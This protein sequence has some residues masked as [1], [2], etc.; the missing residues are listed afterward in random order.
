MDARLSLVLGSTTITTTLTLSLYVAGLGLGG[1]WAG[2]RR[3]SGPPRG[4]T[5]C[6]SLAPRRRRPVHRRHRGRGPAGLPR[7]DPEPGTALSNGQ[8]A[9]DLPARLNTDDAPWI[10]FEAPWWG[11]RPTAARN[12]LS[13]RP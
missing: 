10:E 3:W 1:A 4:A 2:R 9:D 7:A 12:G 5:A 13:S 11:D 6:G 8:H